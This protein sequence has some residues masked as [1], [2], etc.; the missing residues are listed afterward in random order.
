MCFKNTKRF[1]KEVCGLSVVIE[2]QELNGRDNFE[3][4][5][6]SKLFYEFLS[7]FINSDYKK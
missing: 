1:R 6:D 5:V 7:L 2:L 4:P 3:F